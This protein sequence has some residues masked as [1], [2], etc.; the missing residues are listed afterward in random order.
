MAQLYRDKLEDPDRAVELF[1]ESLDQN[2]SLPRRDFER[3]NKI[4]TQEKNWKQLERQYR[5][6]IHRVAGKG[7]VRIPGVP[8][9]APARSDLPRSHRR[10]RYRRS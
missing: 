2:P 7:N 3:I 10:N 9:L 5:K 4:L 8:A 6:M 1:N